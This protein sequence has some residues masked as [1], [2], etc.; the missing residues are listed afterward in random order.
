MIFL[1]CLSTLHISSAFVHS[2]PIVLIVLLSF[3]SYCSSF[4]L[5]M[6]ILSVIISLLS[7][8]YPYPQNLM[9][10]LKSS[11]SIWISHLP[12]TYL[13]LTRSKLLLVL[14]NNHLSSHL[15]PSV[16]LTI[17]ETYFFQLAILCSTED[18]FYLYSLYISDTVHITKNHS[19]CDC[20]LSLFH[21]TSQLLIYHLPI[22]HLST[23][24]ILQLKFKKT[25]NYFRL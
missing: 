12:T 15:V 9:N 11:L 17:Y 10:E 6:N 2:I 20:S 22:Y 21:S 18:I 5:E 23:F 8:Y 16:F 3:S 19:T 7:V 25:F 1:W 4:S 24:H 13:T 14:P